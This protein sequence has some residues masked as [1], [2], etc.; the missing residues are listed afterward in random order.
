MSS[1]YPIRQGSIPFAMGW[2]S[3][4]FLGDKQ[5]IHTVVRYLSSVMPDPQFHDKAVSWEHTSSNAT[6]LGFRVEGSSGLGVAGL[7]SKA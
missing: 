3:D 4:G 6:G 5:F 7:K 2:P 1:M